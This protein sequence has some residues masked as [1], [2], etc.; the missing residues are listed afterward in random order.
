M[1]VIIEDDKKQAGGN[2]SDVEN[3]LHAV[4][5]RDA[6]RWGQPVREAA[7]SLKSSP[8]AAAAPEQTRPTSGPNKLR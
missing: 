7:D 4:S 6:A 3:E 2:C 1:L 8:A 5:S